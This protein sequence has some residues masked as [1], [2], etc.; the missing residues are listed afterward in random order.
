VIAERLILGFSV[1]GISAWSPNYLAV[2]LLGDFRP[3]YVR[4]RRAKA[5]REARQRGALRR[6]RRAR[7]FRARR[8]ALG[9]LS[10]RRSHAHRAPSTLRSARHARQKISG[11]RTRPPL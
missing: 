10:V 2:A 7:H 9:P 1:I 11:G 5:D 4:L 3:K 8:A 6:S